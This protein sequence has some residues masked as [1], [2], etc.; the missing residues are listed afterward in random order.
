MG[1]SASAL[2]GETRT[3]TW[4]RGEDTCE[5]TYRTGGLTA[6][7][8]KKAAKAEEGDKS[9]VID[10]LLVMLSDILESWEV[11]D[12]K[13]KMVPTTV[14]GMGGLPFGFLVEVLNA[15]QED[16]GGSVGEAVPGSPGS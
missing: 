2:T 4:V 16:M 13:G 9:A 5:I 8:I 15:I 1:I 14:E 3:F 12:D 6:D 10:K 7:D 11:L